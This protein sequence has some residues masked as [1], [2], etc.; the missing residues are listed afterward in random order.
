METL[1]CIDW[2]SFTARTSQG[3]MT[4]FFPPYDNG[5]KWSVETPKFGYRRAVRTRTG[6]LIMYD[7]S[8]ATMGT[9]YQYNGQALQTHFSLWG[10]YDLILAWHADGHHKCTRIDLAI[11]VLNAPG[12]L[13]TVAAQL[14]AKRYTGS[15]RSITTV[16]S[17]TGP[18]Q[19]IYCGSRQ[20]E[21]FVRI[22]DKAA[23]TGTEGAWARIEVECKGDRA[24]GVLAALTSRSVA[25]IGELAQ[26]V[27]Q[28][29]V[30]LDIQEWHDVFDQPF[31]KLAPPDIKE[32]DTEAWV[33]GVVATA[34][35][36]FEQRYPEK[37]LADR[38]F[39]TLTMALGG[40]PDRD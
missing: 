4:D 36:K 15:A 18:G 2:L 35:I 21:L 30:K 25:S 39:E 31:I 7:G 33:L 29:V 27:I 17:I 10:D 9:H 14:E 1:T 22:Y 40:G 5:G 28:H 23:Q 32:H 8:V 16:K 12:W 6:V 20:S 11:D 34:L 19:T 37:R 38:L 26:S 24:R 3:S 13:E